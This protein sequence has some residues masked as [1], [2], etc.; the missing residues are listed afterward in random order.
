MRL[1]ESLGSS[2]AS[3]CQQAVLMEMGSIDLIDFQVGS[4]EIPYCQVGKG[5]K[6]RLSESIM[7]SRMSSGQQ[8]VL[9]KMGSID[10]VNCQVG[11]SELSSFQVGNG[12]RSVEGLA[13]C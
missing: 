13:Y 1:S 6:M 12:K 8:G 5:E 9:M 10:L 2:K 11:R 3:S 7:N 4:R